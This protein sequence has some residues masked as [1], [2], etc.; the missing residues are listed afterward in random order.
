MSEKSLAKTQAVALARRIN[1]N[2]WHVSKHVCK[3]L[4]T[5]FCFYIGCF[6]WKWK[7]IGLFLSSF[8]GSFDLQSF[9]PCAVTYYFVALRRNFFISFFK[10]IFTCVFR[11]YF[12]LVLECLPLDI[13][14]DWK[15][16]GLS[17]EVNN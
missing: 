5:L 10:V 2:M 4:N 1:L 3:I 8:P 13:I 16:C 14:Q 6:A 11:F 12:P 7:K 15:F 9:F 17:S